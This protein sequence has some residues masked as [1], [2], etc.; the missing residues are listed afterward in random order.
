VTPKPPT[1]TESDTDELPDAWLERGDRLVPLKLHDT[2]DLIEVD[3]FLIEGLRAAANPLEMAA[4]LGAVRKTIAAVT[5][6]IRQVERAAAADA[7]MPAPATLKAIDE[8]SA[9]VEAFER[10]LRESPATALADSGSGEPIGFGAAPD[11]S[12]PS[13]KQLHAQALREW[14]DL[15]RA[16]RDAPHI[17]RAQRD[18]PGPARP[19]HNRES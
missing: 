3:G 18:A 16:L 13:L 5:A 2:S 1:Y 6:T 4:R 10:N 11:P 14:P 12:D 19:F 7:A 15:E 17:E 9:A 8:I